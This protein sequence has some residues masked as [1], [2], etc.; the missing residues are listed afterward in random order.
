MSCAL[1]HKPG[2][3]RPSTWN[4]RPM[5]RLLIRS[6]KDPFTPVSAE[7]TLTQD[8]FNSNSGNYLFQHAVWKSLAID[9]TELVPN[10]TLS[11]RR[12]P[13]GGD[14][15]RVN[16]QFDHFVI[17][18]ANAFRPGF[19]ERLDRLS[20]LLE[21]V[22]IPVTV[23]GIGA[24]AAHGQGVESLAP[25]ADQVKRFVSL[26]LDRSASI[27]VR[28]V[29]T[30]T[31]LTQLGFP[32]ESIDIIGCPSLFLHG[33]DFTVQR[34]VGAV[35]P[36]SLL[37]M[38]LTPEVP[39][40]GAFAT[41]HAERYPRLTY[42]PQDAHDLRLMLWGVPS[43]HVHDRSVPV[44][45]DHRLYTEDRMRLFLD[46]WPWYDFM[47]EHDFAY[48]TRFHGNVAALL[49]GTPA[50]LLAHDSRTLELAEHHHMP[51]QIL[52][53]L[54]ADI[55]AEELYEATDL[56]AFNEAMPANFDRYTAFL[57]RNGLDHIWAGDR[58]TTEFDSSLAAAQ[59]PPA[60]RTLAGGLGEMASRLQWLRRG[61]TLDITRHPDRYK[62]PYA[63]P[64]WDG[65][66]S[67]PA[68]RRRQED[69]ARRALGEQIN[70]LQAR[71]ERLEQLEHQSM[72]RRWRRLLVRVRRRLGR[73]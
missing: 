6:G 27:G 50:M 71:L 9:G 15:A 16:E 51:H 72:S 58:S 68:L 69:A 29:F 61:M 56:S 64:R 1:D 54:T 36:D 59:L 60:V 37:A 31:Y 26:V 19:V 43:P 25:I 66:G 28:G 53:E 42:V 57:E 38:N 30:Q 11:E 17:P 35:G 3:R 41:A 67:R 34:K 52:P 65:I 49:G 2:G 14:A 20:D 10:G 62:Y 48:G 55:T 13:A 24:Q 5:P 73:S 33:R 45:L 21:G 39:G 32:E 7:T 44:H 4:T 23:T 46:T 18:L 12:A 40:I 63:H 47:A 8:V 22:T 70:H